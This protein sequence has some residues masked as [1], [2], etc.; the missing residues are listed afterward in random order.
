MTD[1]RNLSTEQLLTIKF[2]SKCRVRTLEKRGASRTTSEN[3]ELKKNR[4]V[5][6]EV[7]REIAK[8]HVQLPLF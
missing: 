4:A 2:V 1:Y 8:R 6:R 7:N 5:V 3:E